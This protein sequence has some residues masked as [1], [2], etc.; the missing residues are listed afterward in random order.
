[1]TDS[2]E[3]DYTAAVIVDNGSYS[4]KA[5][6]NNHDSPNAVIPT[7]SNREDNGH[8]SDN[9]IIPKHPIINGIITNYNEM[10]CFFFLLIFPQNIFK[11]RNEFHCITSVYISPF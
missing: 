5:G 2:E 1:M 7:I 8:L 11:Q 3:D 10:V 6:F 4:I 9:N